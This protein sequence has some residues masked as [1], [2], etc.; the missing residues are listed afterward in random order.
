[1]EELLFEVNKTLKD[2]GLLLVYEYVG[3]S[4]WNFSSLK[5][6]MIKKSLEEKFNTTFIFHK[7]DMSLRPLEST[8]SVEIPSLFNIYFDKCKIFEYL[9]NPILYSG[10]NIASQIKNKPNDSDFIDKQI[11]LLIELNELNENNEN[12]IKTEFVGLYKKNKDLTKPI[13]TKP[14]TNKEIKTNLN[15]FGYTKTKLIS[16][17]R[18]CL[19]EF[20]FKYYRRIYGKR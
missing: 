18:Q 2:D 3:E 13:Y 5:K 16:K 17:L 4:K 11:Q 14:W 7:R 10:I 8:R 1:M 12:L 6:E 19:P 20:I 9:W 15:S